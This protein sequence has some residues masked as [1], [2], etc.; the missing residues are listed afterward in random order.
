MAP[1]QQHE[2]TTYEKVILLVFW[3]ACSYVDYGF[4]L[5]G[6]TQQ[7]PDQSHV[8]AVIVLSAAGPVAFPGILLFC[9]PLHWRVKPLTIEEQWEY[10]HKEYPELDRAYFDKEH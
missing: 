4:F 8:G 10:F 9:T 5:G 1:E 7:F 6:F 3:L 2:E